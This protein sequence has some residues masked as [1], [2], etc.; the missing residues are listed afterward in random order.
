M[1]PE[2]LIAQCR[3]PCLDSFGDV[4][5]NRTTSQERVCYELY[6]FFGSGN[7]CVDAHNAIVGRL[8]EGVNRKMTGA[9]NPT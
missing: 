3:G 9:A 5:G 6:V 1:L 8:Q 2:N 4:N 7:C